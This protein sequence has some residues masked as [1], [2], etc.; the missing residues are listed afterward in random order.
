M[1]VTLSVLK[2]LQDIDT[3]LQELEERR[4][5]LPQRVEIMRNNVEGKQRELDDLKEE[6]EQKRSKR[7]SIEANVEEKSDKLKKLKKQLYQVKNNREYDA[8][9]TEIEQSQMQI[10]DMVYENMQLD[11]D[12]ETIDHQINELSDKVNNLQK[13]FEDN[14]KI[15]DSKLMETKEQEDELE[16]ERGK[17]VKKLTKP[18]LNTYERIRKA[19]RGKAVAILRN[20]TCSECSSRVPPQHSLEIRTHKK[21]HICEVCGRILIWDEEQE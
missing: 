5:D 14:K 1:Q 12:I 7:S 20:D 17:V 16:A 10:D 18:V 4:G 13:D 3:Q 9:T 21:M 19:R 8:I 2:T 11:E 15:L 6:R